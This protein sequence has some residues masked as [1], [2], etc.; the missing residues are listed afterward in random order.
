MPPTEAKLNQ[1]IRH[2][3]RKIER[4]PNDRAPLLRALEV[5]G[6]LKGISIVALSETGVGKTVNGLKRHEDGE[7]AARAKALVAKWKELV[8]KEEEEGENPIP[9]DGKRR[10]DEGP[11]ER[12]QDSEPK[13][14]K[15]KK[16]GGPGR[17]EDED[18]RKTSRHHRER[19]SDESR[20]S[21]SSSSSSRRHKESKKEPSTSTSF[22][23]RQRDEP[24]SST[25]SRQ[26]H[27]SSRSSK[28]TAYDAF[29][30]ALNG[31]TETHSASQKQSKRTKASSSGSNGGCRRSSSNRKGSDADSINSS[32]N[33]DNKKEP[34]DEQ[35]S[36][37]SSSCVPP[38]LCTE[39]RPLRQSLPIRTTTSGTLRL[40]ATDDG[41]LS[42]LLAM[43][44]A[45]SGRRSAVYSG[46]KRSG[47]FGS[48]PSLQEICVR[49]LQENVD[50][51][52]ECGGLPYSILRP[53]FERASPPTLMQIEEYNPYLMEDT[54]ELWERFVHKNFPK[55]KRE[56]M[57][58]WREVFE[59]CTLEREQKLDML[60]TKVKDTYKS[61]DR[62]L[63]KT[64]LA[65]VDAVAKPPRGVRKA[66]ERNGI[67]AQV[68]APHKKGSERLKPVAVKEHMT[69]SKKPKVAPMMAKTLRMM[70]GFKTGFR[71]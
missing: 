15:P 71:R 34:D 16:R 6:S 21:S 58:T 13:R 40:G 7:V 60:K 23:P 5:L 46:A 11:G 44:R 29:D 28:L 57:E 59:R 70:K 26:H 24:A 12:A 54:G 17:E 4:H 45:N 38:N 55:N 51:I 19:E 2:Y 65:Y 66:Q 18:G 64:K 48:V 35:P 1:N 69:S 41:A 68:G 30:N 56:E 31:L 3:C 33:S 53:I 52:A 36:P 49:T 14:K 9:G 8:Q 20:L 50:D 63:K 42:E 22:K 67:F 62:N 27:K 61:H 37:S 32:F 10:E 43:R 47:Y 39:Y 25:S